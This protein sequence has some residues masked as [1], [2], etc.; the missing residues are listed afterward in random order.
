MGGERGRKCGVERKA[1]EN[2]ECKQKKQVS[3]SSMNLLAVALPFLKSC[4]YENEDTPDRKS[5]KFSLRTF[6]RDFSS[7]LI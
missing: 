3:F 1:R 6:S 7:K 5:F 4:Y 2:E